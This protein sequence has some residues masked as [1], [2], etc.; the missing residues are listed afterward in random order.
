MLLFV[1]KEVVRSEDAKAILVRDGAVVT[2]DVLAALWKQTAIPGGKLSPLRIE[3][4]N[5]LHDGDLRI[6]PDRVRT[7]DGR[8]MLQTVN[9]PSEALRWKPAGQKTKPAAV[10]TK[11]KIIKIM[12]AHSLTACDHNGDHPRALEPMGDTSEGGVGNTKNTGR[13]W[14]NLT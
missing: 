7:W 8:T 5:M 6:A 11:A 13:R 10:Q 14:D 3:I 9:G 4:C 1:G 2:R 12:G